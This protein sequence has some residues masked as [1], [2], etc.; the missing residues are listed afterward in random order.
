MRVPRTRILI[1]KTS[2]FFITELNHMFRTI[3]KINRDYF[4]KL[5]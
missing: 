3:L 5:H 2:V 4:S 1:F